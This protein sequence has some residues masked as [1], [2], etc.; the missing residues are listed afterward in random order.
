[1][2]VR[3]VLGQLGC[4][5]T[6]NAYAVEIAVLRHQLAVLRRQVGRPKYAAAG[7]ML[8]AALAKL[9]PRERWSVFLVTHTQNPP[10]DQQRDGTSGH[11]NELP[12]R[13]PAGQHSNPDAAPHTL[14]AML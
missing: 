6:P 14:H 2:I 11:V 3:R 9:L 1:M 4:D 13:I 10:N 7:R 5:P 12:D 8:L